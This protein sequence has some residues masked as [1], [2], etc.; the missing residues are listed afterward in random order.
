MK[1]NLPIISLGSP[2][3]RLS[4]DAVELEQNADT[5]TRY[6]QDIMEI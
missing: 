4:K 1:T 2:E 5:V 6:L 3:I